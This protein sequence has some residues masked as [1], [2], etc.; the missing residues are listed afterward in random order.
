LFD[1]LALSWG[2]G[3]LICRCGKGYND[4]IV[5]QVTPEKRRDD[6]ENPE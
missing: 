3:F 1:T 6:H 5:K 4:Y 2:G